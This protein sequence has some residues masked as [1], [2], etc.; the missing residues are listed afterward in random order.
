MESDAIGK[1]K[2]KSETLEL[3]MLQFSVLQTGSV[4]LILMWHFITSWRSRCMSFGVIYMIEQVWPQY[5]LITTGCQEQGDISVKNANASHAHKAACCRQDQA[6]C[7]TLPWSFLMQSLLALARQ[8]KEEWVS[9]IARGLNNFQPP[10]NLQAVTDGSVEVENF[11]C[12]CSVS[13]SHDWKTDMRVYQPLLSPNL[14]DYALLSGAPIINFDW[15]KLFT[16]QQHLEVAEQN[17]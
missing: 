15:T 1:V 4:S 7:L 6:F 10:L 12:T 14:W 17:N 11:C 9:I 16:R 8:D 13:H 2:C 3:H 5:R